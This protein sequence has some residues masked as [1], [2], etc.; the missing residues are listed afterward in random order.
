MLGPVAE[1]IPNWVKTSTNSL[2]VTF[3]KGI[4]FLLPPIL[5]KRSSKGTLNGFTAG[6]GGG[7]GGGGLG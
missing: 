4:M 6:G 5:L 2:F 7:G 3:E 1:R